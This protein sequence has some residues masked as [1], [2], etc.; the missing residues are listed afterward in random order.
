MDYAYDPFRLQNH[1]TDRETGLHYNF[2]R[3]YKSDARPFVNQDPIG[4]GRGDNLYQFA[5]NTN[6]WID[7]LGLNKNLPA[8]YCPP[9]R[10][11]L[12][13]VRSITL[14]IGTLV[15]RWYRYPGGTL[16]PMRDLSPGSNRKPYTIY[17]PIDNVAAS[18]IMSLFGEIG[19]G[20]QYEL[21][22]S[23]KSY[24]ESGHLEE[25]KIGKC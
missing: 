17:R 7:V 15:D 12:G 2:F 4:L 24:I 21:P 13:E 1:Y 11:A 3:Y 16:Y 5:L 22:K 6:K 18:K 10:G 25:V 19:L 20:T 14:P 8:P 23:V 9:N